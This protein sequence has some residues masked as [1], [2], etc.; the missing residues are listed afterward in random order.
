MI[1]ILS[2]RNGRGWGDGKGERDEE[3]T[4]VGKNRKPNNLQFS[5]GKDRTP[6]P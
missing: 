1:P 3:A 5:Q 4:D 6:I 2:K